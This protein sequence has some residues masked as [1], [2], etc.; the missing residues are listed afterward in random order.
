MQ[1]S[2]HS[3][4]AD[5]TPLLLLLLLFLFFF[6]F[7]LSQL[8]VLARGQQKLFFLPVALRCSVS[9]SA[10]R[11]FLFSSLLFCSLRCID[12][13]SFAFCF[14]F[15][16]TAVT[17]SPAAV[18]IRRPSAQIRSDTRTMAAAAASACS[19]SRHSV[20][21]VNCIDR[22]AVSAAAS[23]R[24]PQLRP[25]AERNEWRDSKKR[26]RAANRLLLQSIEQVRLDSH[27]ISLDSNPCERWS[28]SARWMQRE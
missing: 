11:L 15:A 8:F 27:C 21:C 20:I 24:T 19:C 1:A 5:L 2:A 3:P 4:S 23:L 10:A 17:L 25:A 6:F 7:L 9:A 18:C 28:L 26:R 16:R 14:T 12:L 22:G 13:R